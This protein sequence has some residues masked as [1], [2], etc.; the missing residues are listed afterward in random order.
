MYGYEYPVPLS[1]NPRVSVNNLDQNGASVGYVS[2]PTCETWQ[3]QVQ[4]RRQRAG[5]AL[6]RLAPE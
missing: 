5:I 3:Q 2:P 1:V 4:V 6:G